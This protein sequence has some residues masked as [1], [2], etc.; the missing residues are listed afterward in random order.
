MIL[1][2][3]YDFAVSKQ[4]VINVVLVPTNVVLSSLS[5]PHPCFAYQNVP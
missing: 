4:T 2:L 1:V 5:V 3:L